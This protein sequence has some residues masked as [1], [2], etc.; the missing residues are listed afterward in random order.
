MNKICAYGLYRKGGLNYD[1]IHRKSGIDSLLYKK[2]INLPG[3]KMYDDIFSPTIEFTGD[4][5]DKIV[6]DLMLANDEVY[7]NI[8]SLHDGSSFFEQLVNIDDEFYS[9]FIEWPIR[10]NLKEVEDGN[11]IQFYNY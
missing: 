4:S 1:Y 8:I 7:K 5:K 3:Y 10:Q 6:V 9:I 11:W 2:T